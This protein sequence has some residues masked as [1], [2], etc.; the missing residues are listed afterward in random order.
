LVQQQR[1]VTDDA[2]T[3]PAFIELNLV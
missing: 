3:C 2:R 1:I